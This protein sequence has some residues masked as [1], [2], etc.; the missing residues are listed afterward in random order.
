VLVAQLLAAVERLAPTSLAEDWDNVGLLVGRSNHPV[1]GVLV[2][3][4]LR[5][6]VLGEAREHGCDAVVTH[7]PPIFPA[8]TALTDDGTAA[9]LVL[10]A[11]ESRVAVIAA[12]FIRVRR[13]EF[14]EHFPDQIGE[15]A[16]GANQRQ[17]LRVAL[18]H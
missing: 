14:A 1:R 8:L 17:Q 5:D 9:E 10:R 3:L 13:A 11:A 15:L 6:E 2:A 12:D 16:P 4:E 18:A 7:H